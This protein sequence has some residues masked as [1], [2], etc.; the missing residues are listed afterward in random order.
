MAL[1]AAHVMAH[2]VL[3]PLFLFVGAVL[4]AG[5]IGLAGKIDQLRGG[6][7]HGAELWP[8]FPAALALVLI[9]GCLYR[10]FRNVRRRTIREFEYVGGV[11]HYRE[12]EH[13]E[14]I[15]QRASYIRSIGECP[16]GGATRIIF[17]DRSWAVLAS[18]TENAAALLE[19]LARDRKLSADAQGNG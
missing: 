17:G 6:R 5:A 11:L 14:W 15:A 7:G 2:I 12:G 10:Y 18:T 9:A 8:C 19:Q 13:D 4:I 16:G 3:A 1:L